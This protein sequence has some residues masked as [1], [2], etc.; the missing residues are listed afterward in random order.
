MTLPT[1]GTR[2]LI[3]RPVR[4]GDS[5][6]LLALF[7]DAERMRFWGHGP[8]ETAEDADDYVREI[9][10]GAERGDLLQWVVAPKDQ[11]GRLIGTCTLASVDSTHRRAELGV[12]LLA[13]VE[14]EGY[15]E[16]AARATI[17]YA[18]EDLDLHR[19]TADADP[20]NTRALT[21]LERLGFRREGLLREHYR[22]GGE[23]QDGVLF[24]LLRGEQ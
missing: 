15:A 6:A 2:R 13:A 9:R 11:D 1:L 3:L 24:G 19:I 23:W 7:G 5:D 20:R 18:F 10:A 17:R 22:Q 4:D 12:A 16:E 8:L 21:L 14:R